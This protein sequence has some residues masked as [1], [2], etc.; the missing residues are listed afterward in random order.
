M[1]PASE[2][3][4]TA[5]PYTVHVSRP[6]G[7]FFDGAYALFLS[8]ILLV[9]SSQVFRF[10]RGGLLLIAL[11]FFVAALFTFRFALRLLFTELTLTQET[12]TSHDRIGGR[13]QLISLDQISAYEI[14]APKKGFVHRLWLRDAQGRTQRLYYS[15]QAFNTHFLREMDARGVSAGR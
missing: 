11:F 15:P 5:R 3:P 13:I 10:G 4:S 6:E 1:Q 2:S 14:E 8:L 9:V 12:L 7:A